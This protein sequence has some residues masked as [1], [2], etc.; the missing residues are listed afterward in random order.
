MAQRWGVSS[1]SVGLLLFPLLVG[2]HT[3]APSARPVPLSWNTVPSSLLVPLD[4]ER[5]AVLYP[6]TYS[7]ELMEAYT[8][9]EGAT[10]QLKAQ[11]PSLRI[12][13][14]FNLP[15]ILGEQRL[16]MGGAVSDETA[17]R[18]G[19]L[20]GV[21]SVLIYRIEGPTLRDRLFARYH[22]DLPPFMVTS[23]IVRV[24]SAEVVFH[25]VVITRMAE[26]TDG[27]SL[28][29]TESDMQP[30]IRAALEHGVAQ[31]VADLWNAFR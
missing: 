10:F 13:E 18:I 4:V 24:E 19:R 23:K 5:L 14:R 6:K 22:G 25:N 12:V 28:S 21:D 7:R 9:L 31:T 20:L 15:S 11:R 8:R 16:Q 26:P 30:L 3:T 1:K 29:L 17:I 2:C 27:A